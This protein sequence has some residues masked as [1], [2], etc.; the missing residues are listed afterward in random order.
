M[1]INLR[2]MRPPFQPVHLCTSRRES[3]TRLDWRVSRPFYFNL[4]TQPKCTRPQK[5]ANPLLDF[6]WSQKCTG[7]RIK[8]GLKGRRR[9]AINEP[10]SPIKF[11]SSLA[12]K[13]G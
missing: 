1:T 8:K 4:F 12:K 3:F 5:L 2:A 10:T 11:G 6:I 7:A 13:G 9:R